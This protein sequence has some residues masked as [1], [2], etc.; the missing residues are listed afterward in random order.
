MGLWWEPS[1]QTQPSTCCILMI[2]APQIPSLLGQPSGTTWPSA[3]VQDTAL[4]TVPCALIELSLLLDDPGSLRTQPHTPLLCQQV[5]SSNQQPGTGS[6]TSRLSAFSTAPGQDLAFFSWCR[7]VHLVTS[8]VSSE[9]TS[10]SRN[11]SFSSRNQDAGMS[12]Q[13]TGPKGGS[14]RQRH[15]L[16]EGIRGL[17]WLAYWSWDPHLCFPES[18][19]NLP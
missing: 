16:W 8:G 14:W 18:L 13:T 5:P 19:L 2:G 1:R 17:P 10:G 7:A 12:G 3:Q 11:A 4:R 6:W 15:I 9:L